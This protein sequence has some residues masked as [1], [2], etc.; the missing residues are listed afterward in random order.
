[1]TS[2][3][4]SP[5]TQAE[6][7]AQPQRRRG[8][9]RRWLIV[10][11]AIGAVVIAVAGVN[12]GRYAFRE[13]PGPKAVESALQRFRALPAPAAP[14]GERYRF[15]PPGVYELVGEGSEHISF[16]PNS[17]KDGSV[18]PATV[19][20]RADGCWV[21][22]VDYNVA[23]WED[24]QFCPR[25]GQLI[26]AGNS[27]SQ[28]WDFGVAKITNLATF[29]CDQPA[30]V[31]SEQP[32]TTQTYERT[33]SGGNSAISGPTN[34]STVTHIIGPET[35]TIGGTAHATIH[36]RQDATITG[37]QTGAESSDWWLAPNTGLP[38]RMER[39]IKLDSSSPLGGTITY[40]E[41]GSWQM[42]TLEPST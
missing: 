7:A 22:R 38:L 36:E 24:F 35:V 41:D 29:T 5:S 42:R 14:T 40:T 9:R 30:T 32:R 17:Q 13:H 16:P 31:L 3:T 26:L 1:M 4:L 18:M 2:S 6:P 8:R 15:P 12:I 11:A 19:S 20:Y 33:C 37:V 27:N 34:T 21:W 39:H 10:V 23:H 25:G 28:T